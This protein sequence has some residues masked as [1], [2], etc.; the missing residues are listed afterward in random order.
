MRV[1]GF[2]AERTLGDWRQSAA[3]CER[4]PR[5]G[6]ALASVVTLILVLLGGFHPNRA[7]A[8]GRQTTNG[9]GLRMTVETH[10]GIGF[11]YRPV[12]ILITPTKP[13]IADR[14]LNVEF[15]VSTYRGVVLRVDQDIEIPAGMTPVRTTL[16]VPCYWPDWGYYSSHVDVW[17]DGEQLEKLST[18]DLG[19]VSQGG[20]GT[21]LLPILLI[22]GDSLP[23]TNS[24][25]NVLFG[26]QQDDSLGSGGGPI[27][28]SWDSAVSLPTSEL[29][30]HWIDYSSL[31]VVCISLKDLASLKQTN[32]ATFQAILDWTDAGG[33]LWV[34]GVDWDWSRLDQ[35]EGLLGLPQGADAERPS[36][37]GWEVADTYDEEYIGV[38]SMD[39]ADYYDYE[40]SDV[41]TEA[42]PPPQE[43]VTKPVEKP[44]PHFVHRQ[45]GMGLILAMAADDPFPGTSD[46]WNCVLNTVGVDRLLWYR[47]HGIS[48]VE[49]N[50]EYMLFLIPDIGLAPVTEFMV[51]ITLFMVAVGPVNY[52]LMRRWGRL[53]LLVVTIPGSALAVTAVLFVYAI[54][55]D[56][57]GTRVRVRSVTRIDQ[58]RGHA[59]CWARLSY[60]SGMAPRDGLRFP[61][62]VAV[63]PLEESPDMEME[64]L[65]RVTWQNRQWLRSGWLASRTPT[66]YMTMRSRATRRGLDLLESPGKSD[67]IRVKN[68]LDTKILQLVVCAADGQTYWA[69]DIDAG[70]TAAMKTAHPGEIQQQLAITLRENQP[71]LPAGMSDR[72]GDLLDMGRGQRYYGRHYYGDSDYDWPTQ[73]TNRM[74]KSLGEVVPIMAGRMSLAPNSYL[75]I[76]EKSPEVILGVASATEEASLHVILGNW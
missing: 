10:W 60:Y 32:P 20:G 3:V 9:H 45:Y 50:S 28:S 66:Q 6:H 64:Q 18:D 33:N 54:F 30:E 41:E 42:V 23:N 40:E 68:R 47:R 31:D 73:E 52:W 48:M 70:V 65:H 4:L 11:G 76:V 43:P 63:L 51:L 22:V 56:G 46:Q 57:L 7:I 26:I 36:K 14:T 58:S 38:V 16:S 62:D 39:Q 67:E 59:A 25:G 5:V 44:R 17:E 69:T 21:G 13:G 19:F 35:F 72:G 75:A 27:Q 2:I 29:S 34:H 8:Q 24:L 1:L 53:Y 15:V 49:D 74:E 55:A 37:R 61:R 71:A 12:R